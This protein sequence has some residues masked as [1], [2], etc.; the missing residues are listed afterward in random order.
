[1]RRECRERFPGH[2]P[3]RKPLV[4]DPGMYHGTC[5]THV[6]WCIAGSLTRGGGEDVPG[7][8]D[9]CATRNFTYLVRGSK[10]LNSYPCNCIIPYFL[11]V[12]VTT[13]WNAYVQYKWYVCIFSQEGGFPWNPAE[14]TFLLSAFYY[15]YIVLQMPGGYLAERLSGKLMFGLGV[16]V[17]G[18]LNLLMPLMASYGV[19]AFGAMRILCGIAAVSLSY[20]NSASYGIHNGISCTGKITPSYWIRALCMYC[21]SVLK[22]FVVIQRRE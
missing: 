8:P 13:Y 5:V 12:L 7:I 14:Q 17:P 22:C 6:P 10:P 18:F 4:S 21:S 20:G 16:I 3:Q 15:G 11:A 19:A 1:M 2:R 9:A